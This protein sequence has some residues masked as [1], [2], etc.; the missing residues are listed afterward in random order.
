MNHAGA[1]YTEG[2]K[3]YSDA[4]VI[5]RQKKIKKSKPNKEEWTGK[6]ASTSMDT[7]K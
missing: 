7:N 6:K 2:R 4:Q 1:P 5:Q 3:I